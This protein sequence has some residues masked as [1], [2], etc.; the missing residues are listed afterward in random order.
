MVEVECWA[1]VVWLRCL[2]SDMWLRWSV[3]KVVWLRGVL[4]RVVWCFGWYEEVG[5]FQFLLV[6]LALF[7][8]GGCVLFLVLVFGGG[9]LGVFCGFFL[10]SEGKV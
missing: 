1:G 10:L 2:G 9:G 7:F 4:G 6:I 5:G 3:G 8:Q